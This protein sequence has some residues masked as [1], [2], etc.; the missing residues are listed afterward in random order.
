MNNTQARSIGRPVSQIGRGATGVR[1]RKTPSAL[2]WLFIMI[3][4]LLTAPKM[5][6]AI[7]PAPLY[8]IDGVI[9]VLFVYASK[10]SKAPALKP[11]SSL[12]VVWLIFVWIGELMGLITYGAVLEPF[13]LIGRFS[14]GI[15]LFFTVPRVVKTP[16]AVNL[17]LKAIVVS[18]IFTSIVTIMYSLGA[19][20]PLIVK[21]FFSHDFLVPTAERYAQEIL[22]RA[23]AVPA[24][25]GQSLI[26]VSTMTTGFLGVMW[27]FSFL[28]GKWPRFNGGWRKAGH[29]ASMIVPIAMLMT[30]GRAAWLTVMVIGA[31]AFLWGFAKGRWN[32]FILAVCLSIVIYKVGWRSEI[33]MVNRVLEKSDK[34][35]ENPLATV[36]KRLQSYTEPFSH[37]VDHPSWLVAGTG[38]VGQKLRMRGTITNQVFD[39]AG[40]SNHS[41]FG[42][43]YYC[44][45]FVA[46]VIHT[47]IIFFGFRLIWFRLK[48]A[49]KKGAPLYQ[50]TW[51]AFLMAW[52]G[53]L[54]WWLPG[55]AM[56]S[57]GRGVI[58]FFFFYGFMAAMNNLWTVQVGSR[59]SEV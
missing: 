44:Y 18:L 13:Y 40:L 9:A 14:L 38:R 58:L 46:A 26:G 10:T 21:L 6:I 20:R 7:G 2:R 15:S 28:A 30:Y 11:L 50:I 42:M 17:I 41:G 37:L 54:L 57:K 1:L 49:P 16:E 23:G 45:G 5:R 29:I 48:R 53:M 22:E 39:L 52:M 35:I 25:R 24:S 8:M 36:P 34:A 33:F 19:T 12:V 4:I 43:A 27:G 32:I 47:L 31:M 3:V 55:H 59:G 51:Q 56:I